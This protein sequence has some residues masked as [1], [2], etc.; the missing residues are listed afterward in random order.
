MRSREQ[1]QA[2]EQVRYLENYDPLTELPNRKRSTIR[3]TAAMAS[4]NPARTSIAVPS[5]GRNRRQRCVVVRRVDVALAGA[6]GAV[7]MPPKNPLDPAP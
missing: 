3:L 7:K 6:E 4:M 1:Q 2:E 5:L